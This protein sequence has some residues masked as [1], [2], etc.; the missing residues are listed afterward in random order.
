MSEQE[1]KLISLHSAIRSTWPV[2]V[3][4]QKFST[5]ECVQWRL[6]V[7]AGDIWKVAIKIQLHEET[8]EEKQRVSHWDTERACLRGSVFKVQSSNAYSEHYN[9]ETRQPS[10]SSM[11]C[12][13]LLFS[14]YSTLEHICL[15]GDGSNR[16]NVIKWQLYPI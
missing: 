11:K 6:P 8:E 10:K 1:P 7:S 3:C 15:D 2:W 4:L 5:Q 12:W 14:L 16:K 13:I 9:R